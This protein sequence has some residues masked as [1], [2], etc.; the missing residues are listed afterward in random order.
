MQMMDETQEG[1]FKK[2]RRK[3]GEVE[4]LADKAA[5]V[6]T[7][8]VE[9]DPAANPPTD[10]P[11][12]DAPAPTDTMAADAPIDPPVEDVPTEGVTQVAQEE[13]MTPEDSHKEAAWAGRL[14]KREEELAA[15]EAMLTQREEDLN[16]REQNLVINEAVRTKQAEGKMPSEKSMDVNGEMD[17]GSDPLNRFSEDFGDE[18]VADLKAAIA[19][20]VRNA[21]DDAVGAAKAEMSEQLEGIVGGVQNAFSSI[22]DDMIR[23]N[24]ED[25]DEII[26][27]EDF[28]KW[29][30]SLEEEERNKVTDTLSNGST[31]QII[32]LL[33]KFKNR[34][35]AN[36]KQDVVDEA[37]LAAA[38]G[39]RSINASPN[40]GDTQSGDPMS[41]FLRGRRKAI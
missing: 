19:S 3:K 2:G 9:A 6:V 39:V 31:Y 30:E 21:I 41:A 27:S 7:P 32:K 29:P 33:N 37:A 13:P 5:S 11:A 8:E 14:R 24:H 34:S 25:L 22:H 36:P 18:F 10:M 23:G 20:E 28:Q 16:Q 40:V 4:M 1:Q 15:R 17:G 38:A 35:Q 12:T 26:G